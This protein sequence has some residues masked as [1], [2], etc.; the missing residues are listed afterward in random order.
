MNPNINKFLSH[1]FSSKLSN[2][3]G[4]PAIRQNKLRYS[5]LHQV[6]F[7]TLSTTKLYL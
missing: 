5:I 6:F 2:K 7:L 4:R 3:C 1:T